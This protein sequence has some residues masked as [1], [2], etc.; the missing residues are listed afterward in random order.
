M[1]P[2]SP[3]STAESP[4]RFGRLRPIDAARLE[5]LDLLVRRIEWVVAIGDRYLLLAQRDDFAAHMA[6]VHSPRVVLDH[7][8]RGPAGRDE[9]RQITRTPDLRQRG[10]LIEDW[11]QRDRIGDIAALDE[12][13]DCLENVAV[14]RIGEMLGRR[15]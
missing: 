13:S 9:L 3:R 5:S 11:L 15:I 6:L 14:H 7:D 12:L 10:I 1:P 8:A 2:P 4:R